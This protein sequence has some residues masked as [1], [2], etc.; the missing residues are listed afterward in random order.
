MREYYKPNNTTVFLSLIICVLVSFSAAQ[1]DLLVGTDG[2]PGDGQVRRFSN[3]GTFI[4]DFISGGPELD[5]PTAVV[6]GPDGNLYVLTGSD[7]VVRYNGS[8]G[9]FIDIFIPTN[10]NGLDEAKDMIFGPDGNLYI[11]SNCFNGGDGP[12]CPP[13]VVGE[14]GVSCD[15]TVRPGHSL[16][17]SSPTGQAAAAPTDYPK[18]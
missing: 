13:D 3:D 12:D 7:T 8:T 4:G 18:L 1:A 6:F 17:T 11:A 10:S 5:E 2:P 16:T 9:A 14:G 15:L